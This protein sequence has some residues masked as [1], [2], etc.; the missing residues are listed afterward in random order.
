MPLAQ[1]WRQQQWPS[2]MHEEV[3]IVH[4]NPIT[5]GI[6]VRM[7]R[8]LQQMQSVLMAWQAWTMAQYDELA[9]RG[10][11]LLAQADAEAVL[12]ACHGLDCLS[13]MLQLDTT[14][15]VRLRARRAHLE[16]IARH[17]ALNT[18][19]MCSSDTLHCSPRAADHDMITSDKVAARSSHTRAALGPCPPALRHATASHHIQSHYIAVG[20]ALAALLL[21]CSLAQGPCPAQH[22]PAHLAASRHSLAHRR[23]D[24]VVLAYLR[25][26]AAQQQWATAGQTAAGAAPAAAAAAAAGRASLGPPAA[27]AAHRAAGQQVPAQVLDRVAQRDEGATVLAWPASVLGAVLRL[28]AQAAGGALV[29]PGAA[30]TPGAVALPAAACA[31]ASKL[32]SVVR[33]V[34]LVGAG[35]G[36]VE[37]AAARVHLALRW[38]HQ[39]C[40]FA[41][42]PM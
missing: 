40:G 9:Q 18:L 33:S 28:A 25:C 20:M 38:Q 2:S 21:L 3:T 29:A 39:R 5:L 17:V 26:L 27:G 24:F 14:Q 34:E 15:V 32:A 35:A 7:T 10:S 42:P 8:H 31:P 4:A 22:V 19:L 6:S 41:A 12:N 30:G 13:R 11:C 23:S 37:A 16:T 36:G 1:P